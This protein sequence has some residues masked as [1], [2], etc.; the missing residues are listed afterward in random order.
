M[1]MT[2]KIQVLLRSELKPQPRFAAFRER[3]VHPELCP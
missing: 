2:L 1:G 3:A